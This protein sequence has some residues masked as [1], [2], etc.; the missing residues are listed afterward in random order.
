MQ[1]GT[2][3]VH[4]TELTISLEKG[5]H[6]PFKNRDLILKHYVCTYNNIYIIHTLI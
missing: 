4:I 5:I 3:R 6:K 2:K 1:T